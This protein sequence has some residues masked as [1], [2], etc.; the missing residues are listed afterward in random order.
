MARTQSLGTVLEKPEKGV[1]MNS[2]EMTEQTPI[3]CTESNLSTTT[4]SEMSR[5]PPGSKSPKIDVVP[6]YKL[7]ADVVVLKGPRG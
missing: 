5:S 6:Q 1:E 3:F 2:D 7:N 4:N